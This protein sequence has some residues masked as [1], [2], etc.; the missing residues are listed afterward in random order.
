MIAAVLINLY[1]AIAKMVGY[2]GIARLFDEAT[3]LYR[4]RRAVK[5]RR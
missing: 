1:K 4:Q 5:E 2:C 3:W